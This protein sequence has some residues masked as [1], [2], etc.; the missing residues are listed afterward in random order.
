MIT[1][2]DKIESFKKIINEDI[3]SSY[4]A[5]IQKIKQE[6]EDIIRTYKAKKY[7][8]IERI[9]RDYALKLET[10]TDRIHSKTQKEGQN[11]ILAANKQIYDDFFKALKEE[12]KLEYL[13][14]EG[15]TYLKRTLEVAKKDV[16]SDDTIYVFEKS[17]ERDMPIIQDILGGVD[18]QKSDNIRIGGFEVENK[19]RTYRLNYSVDFLLDNKYKDI[20][21]KLKQ[22]L[23]VR[24]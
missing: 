14:K 5:E 15:E 19:E 12:L 7:E 9:K 8:D 3:K 6:T 10:K 24:A 18:I 4:D 22:E 2:E 11:I 21:T 23:D 20:L 1:I 17:Y 16:K 13:G